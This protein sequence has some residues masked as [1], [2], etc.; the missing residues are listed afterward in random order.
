[1]SL[2]KAAD[3]AHKTTVTGLFGFFGYCVYNI[4]NQVM[5]GPNSNKS[6][7]PQEGFIE[8]IREKIDEDYKKFHDI[9]HR[10]WYDKNDDSY[11][12][13]VPRPKDYELKK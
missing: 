8:T 6:D 4:T 5:E 3:I 11:L 9:N 10:E 1:M 12:K 13:Q 7:H 2:R